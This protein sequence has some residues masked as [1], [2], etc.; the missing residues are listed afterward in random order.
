MP[1]STALRIRFLTTANT[2]GGG[3]LE[4]DLDRRVGLENFP[5]VEPFTFGDVTILFQ[6]NIKAFKDVAAVFSGFSA[7]IHKAMINAERKKNR[8]R[9]VLWPPSVDEM[10]KPQDKPAL[11]IRRP[12]YINPP[13]FDRS[14][15]VRNLRT[16]QLSRPIGSQGC[17]F[18]WNRGRMPR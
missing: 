13:G 11:P 18:V 10:N 2:I 1:D 16:K 14:E 12:A 4:E 7:T 9:Y 6:A 3:T 15:A 5:E 17:G 8:D